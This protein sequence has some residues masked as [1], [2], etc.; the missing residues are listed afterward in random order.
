MRGAFLPLGLATLGVAWVGPVSELARGSFS[1]HMTMHMAVVA[2]AA[3]LIALGVRGGRLDPVM[4]VPWL[5]APVP[6]S[7]V[8]LVVVWGWHVPALHHAARHSLL[9][10]SM[11]QGSFILSGLWLWLSVF[12]GAG[13]E[14]RQRRGPGILALLLTS[15]HMTLLGA[16]LALAPRAL[17]A[18]GVSSSRLTPLE[19][20]HLGGALM[21]VIGG[22]AYLSGGLWLAVGLL[23]RE[24][25]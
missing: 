7:V 17:Y 16:L 23:R 10:F 3:P 18:H 8:E 13:E 19:D 24:R 15:M 11:E 6:A 22:A 1:G 9:G 25:P 14:R 20:Q 4:R 5:F 2:V 12:G 21:L